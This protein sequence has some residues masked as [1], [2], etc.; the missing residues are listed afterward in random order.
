MAY[1]QIFNGRKVNFDPNIQPTSPGDGDIWFESIGSGVGQAGYWEWNSSLNLWLG[2]V[3][4]LPFAVATTSAAPVTFRCDVPFNIS[5]SSFGVYV[6]NVFRTGSPQGTAHSTVSY[7]NINFGWWNG[8]A[9]TLIQINQFQTATWTTA[10]SIFRNNSA[11]N[12]NYLNPYG[13][14]VSCSKGGTTGTP[15]QI[16]LG[17]TMDFR[18]T[19]P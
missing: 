7:W 14:Y 8:T 11:V 10:N 2:G 15:G 13:F 17:C 19:R 12:T 6:R 9:G 4:H 1:T 16:Y 5:N 3:Q 18:V